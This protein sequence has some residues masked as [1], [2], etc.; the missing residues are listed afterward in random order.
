MKQPTPNPSQEG[1]IKE[2]TRLFVP[3]LG[4]GRGGFFFGLFLFG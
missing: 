3:L 2:R 1:S 4:G